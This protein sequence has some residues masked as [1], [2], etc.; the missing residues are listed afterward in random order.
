MKEAIENNKTYS[1]KFNVS[2]KATGLENEIE[3]NASSIHVLRV[4]DNLISTIWF[5]LCVI[6]VD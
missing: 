1:E 5:V 3:V 4:L 2:I 6:Q